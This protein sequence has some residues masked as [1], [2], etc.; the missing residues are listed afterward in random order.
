[1]KQE[2]AV[3][4]QEQS[5]YKIELLEKCYTSS[6]DIFTWKYFTSFP[7]SVAS[8]ERV[9]SMKMRSKK[10]EDVKQENTDCNTGQQKYKFQDDNQVAKQESNQCKLEEEGKKVSRERAFPRKEKP[11]NQKRIAKLLSCRSN[12]LKTVDSE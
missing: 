9:C 2:Y 3:K 7:T 6:K 11:N 4:E 8:C 5:G 10:E 12:C 1:M